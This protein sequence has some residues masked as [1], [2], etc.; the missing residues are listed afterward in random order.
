MS[1]AQT[2]YYLGLLKG[3]LRKITGWGGAI[4]W[5]YPPSPVISSMLK[6]PITYEVSTTGYDLPKVNTHSN[7]SCP[8]PP[9][10][11]LR[12]LKRTPRAVSLPVLL[13]IICTP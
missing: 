4:N 3:A 1:S 11:T 10:L 6:G 2:L 9:S 8:L 5:L 12:I 7:G 13:E